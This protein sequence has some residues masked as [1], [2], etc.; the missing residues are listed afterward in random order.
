M[1]TADS[2]ICVLLKCL[3]GK[4]FVD[5][6]QPYNPGQI[7]RVTGSHALKSK[8]SYNS[9]NKIDTISFFLQ[10]PC[11]LLGVNAFDEFLE[12]ISNVARSHPNIQI[13]V[14]EHPGFPLPPLLS[15]RCKLFKY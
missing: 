4:C 3:L 8:P 2:E 12:L 14:R 7:F 13:I 10:S 9:D 15:I 11:A 6:L 5:R 1:C